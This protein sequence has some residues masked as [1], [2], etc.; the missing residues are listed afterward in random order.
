LNLERV[1]DVVVD[2]HVW[3]QSI[4]L[5]NHGD[6]TLPWLKGRDVALADRDAATG[7][8]LEPGD[9]AQQRRLAASGWPQQR[10]ELAIGDL[11][12][13]IVDAAHAAGVLLDEIGGCDAGH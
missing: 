1:R 9:R 10:E 13:Q 7:C 3:E 5:E 4:V 6:M 12:A 2:R 8:P 11:E